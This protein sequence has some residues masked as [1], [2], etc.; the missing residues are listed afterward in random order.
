[1][2]TATSVEVGNLEANHVTVNKL[3]GFLELNLVSGFVA[4]LHCSVKGGLRL[5]FY[6]V[7]TM[8]SFVDENS[9]HWPINLYNATTNRKILK[10]LKSMNLFIT[11]CHN[12][13]LRDRNKRLVVGKY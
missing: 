2:A 12:T 6:D 13:G 9:Y 10:F 1:M 7:L 4:H 3:V 5:S 8:L 11:D